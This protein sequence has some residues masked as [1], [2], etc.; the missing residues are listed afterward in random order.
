MAQGAGIWIATHPE[1]V[2][3]SDAIRERFLLALQPTREKNGR[4]ERA[5]PMPSA[6]WQ[7]TARLLSGAA[8]STNRG[9]F[10]PAKPP[11]CFWVAWVRCMQGA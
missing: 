4:G 5:S 8:S 11:V 2:S 3:W 9:P 7:W 10:D 1:V 6:P